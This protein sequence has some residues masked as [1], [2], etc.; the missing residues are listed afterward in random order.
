M[1]NS[2]VL[3]TLV[4]L[5][6]VLALLA[7]GLGV[8][9]QDSGNSFDFKTVRGDTVTIQGHGLYKYDSANLVSQALGQDVVTLL[10]GLPLLAAG[11]WMFR[12]NWLRGKLLLA[13]TLAYFLYAY[14]T[15][16]FGSA[17]NVLFLVYV[18]LFS[19]SLFAFVLTLL[20]IDVKTLALHISVHL[21][22]KTIAGYFFLLG[23]FLLVA[24]SGRIVPALLDNSTPVGLESSTTLFVQVM[25]L[26]IIMPVAFLAGWLLLKKNAW[27]YLLA[28]V[29]LFHGLTMGLAIVAMVITQVLA[30]DEVNVAEAGIFVALVLAGLFMTYIFFENVKEEEVSEE[31][32]LPDHPLAV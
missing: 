17:F 32:S 1:K 30:G 9:W 20:T 3:F 15:Y 21:P 19:L 29:S 2:R 26:G 31:I 28:A 18:A 13:G 5:I 27:G 14:T 6:G 16:A 4:V 10:V 24:W 22:R 23:L 11:L 8:F 25:D 12:K 7:A